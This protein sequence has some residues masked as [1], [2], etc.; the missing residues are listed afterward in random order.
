MAAAA[1]SKKVYEIF[2]SRVPWTVAGSKSIGFRLVFIL[3]LIIMSV[4]KY[5]N[6]LKHS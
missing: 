2:V 1:A 5:A 4:V 6:L 3:L